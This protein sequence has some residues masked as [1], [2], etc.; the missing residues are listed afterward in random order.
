MNKNRAQKDIFY[1]SLSSFILVVA[2]VGFSVY[3]K[4][5][6]TTISEDLQMQLTPIDAT[7]DTQ[8][9]QKLKSRL[10]VTPMYEVINTTTNTTPSPAPSSA[11]STS[12]EK[13][14]ET[15]TP[16]PSITKVP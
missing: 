8:V 9:I 15:I 7:F 16:A 5:T 6:T 4:W 13:V 10:N 1:I 12:A 3:H 2:W 14:T 11:A